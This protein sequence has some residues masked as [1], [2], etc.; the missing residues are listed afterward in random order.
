MVSRRGTLKRLSA[1]AGAMGLTGCSQYL[2]S[3][4]DGVDLPPNPYA[5][6]LPER[7]H[8]T[9]DFVRTDAA[10]NELTPRYHQVLLLDLTT[11][12]SMEA[13][14][15]VERAMRTIEAAY[16]WESEGLFH[17]LAWGTGYFER[18]GKLG[19]APISPP[20]VLSRTD[21]PDLQAFDAA[22]VL[23]SDVPSQ[24]A[25]TTNAMFRSRETLGGVSVED[26]LGDVFSVRTR[27]TGFMGEG[28]PRKHL[29]AEGLPEASQVPT[30][31]PMFTGFFSGR[32]RTQA[33]EDRVT[34]GDGRFAGGTTMHLS[35]LRISLD[36]WW[37]SFDD[38]ERVARMFSPEF[39]PDDVPGFEVDVPFSDRVKEHAQEFDVVGHHEKVA[40]VRENGEPIVLRRDF[41]TVDG[42]EPG[43]HFLSFQRRLADFRKTRKAM[44]GW[45]VR[46]DSPEIRDRQNNG[47]LDIISVRS[48][49]NFYVPPREG[50]SFPLFV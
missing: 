35:S 11:E 8:A 44:N 18:I 32:K 23:S 41:N 2:A 4:T 6:R 17:Q 13:A 46:D 48:R 31:A 24:I 19:A 42:G 9:T 27:R 22:L 10:G 39:S 3:A 38:A 20:Q 25:A 15:Q 45:Y 26:R 49:A 14:K 50:R 1:V 47:L 30:D 29:D 5:D 16:E 36:H 28:L 33:S 12:P 21:N 34:I 37:S 7:Q 43:L 40:Q